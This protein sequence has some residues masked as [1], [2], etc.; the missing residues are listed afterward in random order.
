MMMAS[1]ALSAA[2]TERT[3]WANGIALQY[4]EMGAGP[5]VVLLHGFP[6]SAHSWRYQMPALADAGFRV[7][8]PSLRGYGRS[9]RPSGVGA[10]H[11]DRLADDVRGLAR[12]LGAE[13]LAALVGH[14]WGGAIGWKLASQYPELMERLIVLNAPHPGAFAREL[15]SPRQM[16]RSAYAAF[17][18]IPWLPE[19]VLSAGEFRLVRRALERS[20]RREGA[21]RSEDWARLRDALAEPGALTA[22]L[23]YYRAAGRRLVLGR[24]RGSRAHGPIDVPVLLLW[25]ERDPFLGARLTEGLDRWISRLSVRRVPEAGHWVHWDAPETVTEELL[26]FI[27]RPVVWAR[28]RSPPPE[29]LAR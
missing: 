29:R 11:L 19:L 3:A 7:I 10:Y 21:L 4:F 15:R 27:R 12:A 8:A 9:T 28:R 24:A 13:R 23:N 26:A 2:S 22:A 25:G 14:D 6:D 20:V 18:Q 1:E 5:P 16:A 17:F